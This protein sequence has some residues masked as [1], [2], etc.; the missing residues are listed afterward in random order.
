MKLETI[1]YLEYEQNLPQD[2]KYILSQLKGN[3]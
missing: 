3:Q 2:G 1:S